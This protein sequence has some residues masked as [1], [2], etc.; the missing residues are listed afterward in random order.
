MKHI[1]LAVEKYLK[2]KKEVVIVDLKIS[3]YSKSNFYLAIVYNRRISRY[4]VLYI[5]LDLIEDGKIEDYACYQFIDMMNVNYMLNMIKSVE[6]KYRDCSFRNRV[7]K[8]IDNYGIEINIK[9]GI[10][11]YQFKTT[12]FIPRD[13]EFLFDLIVTIF[14]Y[15]PNIVSGLCE[16]LLTLFKDESEDIKYQK[17]FEF[18]ILRGEDAVLDKMFGEE[19]LDFKKI[20]YL[21]KINNKYFCIISGHIVIIEYEFGV[22][23]TYCDCEDYN[24]YVLTVIRAIRNNIERKFN[25]IM[26]IDKE[27]ANKVRYYLAYGLTSKGIKV[28]HGCFEQII[29]YRDYEDG[30]IRFIEDVEEMET[31]IKNKLN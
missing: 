28:I 16:D 1:G 4:K 23:N 5:P 10:D 3:N 15:A 2:K 13:W 7:N 25:K 17:S 18:D 27:K 11:S 8:L 12:R 19:T 22:T 9:I 21:E 6:E 14:T 26:L 29:S 31:S 30:I 20:K 24:I